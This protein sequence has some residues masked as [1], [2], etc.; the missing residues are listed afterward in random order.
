MDYRTGTI[1]LIDTALPWLSLLSITNL[2]NLFQDTA[3]EA[4]N[5]DMEKL[6]AD[7]ETTTTKLKKPPVLLQNTRKPKKKKRKYN[8]L[9]LT[10]KAEEHESSEAEE[11]DADE[12]ARLAAVAA[13]SDQGPQLLQFDYKGRTSTLQSLSDITAWIEERKKRFPTKARAAEIAEGKRLREEQQRAT[14]QV[15]RDVQEKNRAEVSERQKQ[16]TECERL[17]KKGDNA[18]EE[19][20]A[21]SKRKVEKLRKQLEKEERR[22]VRAEA[23]ALKHKVERN[24]TVGRPDISA[25]GNEN[26]KRKRSDSDGP[27]NAKIEDT[28][29]VKLKLQEVAGIMPDPLTPLSQPTLADEERSPLPKALYA[30]GTA[31]QLN[32]SIGQEGDG[33]SL[34]DM[35]RS[36]QDSRVSFSDSSSDSSS[37]DSED[38]TSSSGSSSDNDSDDEAPDQASIKR[39]NPERVTPPRRAKPKQIC[40]EFLHKGLCKRGSR[41]KYLHELPERGR[42]GSGI[43]EVKRAEGRKERIGLYQRLVEQEKEQ[44]DQEI[45]EAILHLGEK[46]FLAKDMQAV[47]GD[48]KAN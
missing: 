39:T 33:Y 38:V 19:A 43:Q 32:S 34:R 5:V 16:K 26:K 31:D 8:Q 21:K 3:G 18:P 46:G 9:G 14:N 15:R 37:T 45:M 42:R 28:N 35:D 1:H 30:D 48:Q 27:G 20:A 41:C 2:Q 29:L 13:D 23:K 36:I 12:E 24:T 47:N 25:L 40:R 10:P 11:D 7:H 6:S 44:E 4:K 22:I 17:R